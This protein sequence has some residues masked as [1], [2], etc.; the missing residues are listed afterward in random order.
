VSYIESEQVINPNGVADEAAHIVLEGAW[1]YFVLAPLEELGKHVL[2][3]WVKGKTT[4]DMTVNYGKEHQEFSITTDWQRVVFKFNAETITNIWIYFSGDEYWMYNTQLELGDFA[5]DYSKNPKDVEEELKSDI[6]DTKEQ[7][8]QYRKETS[9][10]ILITQESITQSVTA[11]EE[12]ISK[13][14][15]TKSETEARISVTQTGILQTV[16]TSITETRTYADTVASNAQINAISAASTDA[17]NKANAAQAN[18]IADTTNRLK[19]YST[20]TQMNSAIDQRANSITSTVAA[21]YTTKTETTNAINNINV[22]NRN[23]LLQ[24]NQGETGWSFNFQN[25]SY[26]KT[27]V[28]ELGVNACKFTVTTASTGWAVIQYGNINRSIMSSGK[29]YTVEFDI[30]PNKEVNVNV[31]FMQSNGV[32]NTGTFGTKSFA[33]NVWGHYSGTVKFNS[34]AIGSQIVYITGLNSSGLQFTIANLIMVEGTKCGSWTQAPEDIETTITE[35]TTQLQ[36]QISQTQNS[37][38]QTVSATYATN[39]TVDQVKS[40]IASVELTANKINWLVKSGTSSSNFTLTD[41]TAE[42]VASYIN[43]KGLVQFSGLDSSTQTVIT[44]VSNWSSS[45]NTTLIDGGKIYTG[46]ITSDKLNVRDLNAFGATIGGFKIDQN[47]IYSGKNSGI[48]IH[49]NSSNDRYSYFRAGGD[50]INGDEYGTI[51]YGDGGIRIKQSGDINFVL[52]ADTEA[53]GINLTS[54]G[55]AEEGM[56]ITMSGNYSSAIFVDVNGQ[57]ATGIT[58]NSTGYNAWSIKSTDGTALLYNIITNSAYTTSS[59][60]K[61]KH[62][63]LPLDIDTT[64]D[65]IM[66]LKPSSFIYNDNEFERIHHGLIADE[67]KNSMGDKDWGVYVDTSYSFTDDTDNQELKAKQ[68]KGIRYEELITDLIVVVQKLNEEINNLKNI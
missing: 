29:T 23:I 19:S 26:S 62:N 39:G 30:L 32:N 56:R 64:Y 25:G 13:D 35:T 41:R 2:S 53:S 43:I 12:R 50:I 15:Y 51:I 45:S 27:A 66:S 55:N 57:Y 67:V 54:T 11:L 34:I 60:R 40:S 4:G 36:S 10:E 6:E 17:T 18:A 47:S 31:Q 38:L 20:T 28:T 3:F 52:Y 48:E 44:K 68:F 8:E 33:A 7:V 24:T 61:L 42:L 37:I 58:I 5:T 21:T 63:I 22:G 9:A 14:Y 16:S 46:S 65:F 49:N 59:D 1:K